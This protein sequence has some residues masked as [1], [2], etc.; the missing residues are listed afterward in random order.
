M[1]PLEL[2]YVM[3]YLI[4][5]VGVG[6]YLK[7]YLLVEFLRLRKWHDFSACCAWIVFAAILWFPVA[8]GLIGLMTLAAFSL[9]EV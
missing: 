7:S 6:L 8:I 5:G 1:E 3:F 9:E 2:L 4:F